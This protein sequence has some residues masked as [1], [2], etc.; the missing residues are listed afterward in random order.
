MPYKHS[1]KFQT[2]TAPDTQQKQQKKNLKVELF[3]YSEE[4]S[5]VEL[6]TLDWKNL[7]L[8]FS[9]LTL[10]AFI[11]EKDRIEKNK[12]SFFCNILF[13]HALPAPDS[14][15]GIIILQFICMLS[16]LISLLVYYRVP[17]FN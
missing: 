2:L 10:H 4:V 5:Q 11:L 8:T 16:S 14:A 3:W 7:Q 15:L 13:P 9:D 1:K 12:L 6:A 17:L